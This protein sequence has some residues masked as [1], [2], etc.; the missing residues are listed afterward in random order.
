MNCKYRADLNS[1]ITRQG[2]S[3]SLETYSFT[4][5]CIPIRFPPLPSFLSVWMIIKPFILAALGLK[6]LKGFQERRL[7]VS[8]FS[9]VQVGEEDSEHRVAETDS[10]PRSH[11]IPNPWRSCG[12]HFV[13]PEWG[14]RGSKSPLLLVKELT[15]G[16][17]PPALKGFPHPV[18]YPRE[19]QIGEFSLEDSS[20]NQPFLFA[21]DLESC[22]CWVVDGA[23][24]WGGNDCM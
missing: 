7:V 5:L 13:W 4:Y 21:L 17:I 1:S 8:N 12:T 3:G 10:L 24:R 9:C 18:G 15:S 6:V 11:T 14:V 20:R 23:G 16:L 22:S 2:H 19:V